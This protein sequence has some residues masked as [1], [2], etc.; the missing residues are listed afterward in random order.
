MMKPI[1]TAAFAALL[2]ATPASARDLSEVEKNFVTLTLTTMS[3]AHLCGKEVVGGGMLRV[4]DELGVGSEIGVAVAEALSMLMKNDYDRSKL[5][6]EVTRQ[7]NFAT[8]MLTVVTK[9]KRGFCNR[10]VPVLVDRGTLEK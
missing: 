1:A 5:I 3:A 2:F 8:E 10:V 6:P 7:V 4:A 9:D